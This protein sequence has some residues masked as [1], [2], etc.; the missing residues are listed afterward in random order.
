MHLVAERRARRS[1]APHPDTLD[2]RVADSASCPNCSRPIAAD[3]AFCPK[4]G[5]SLP[6]TPTV[7]PGEAPAAPAMAPEVLEE[8]LRAALAPGF[9]LVRRLGA[10]GM[11]SVYLARE[12]A[13]KRLVAVK[14]LAPELTSDAGSRA[15][16]EREAQAVAAFSHPNVVGIFGVGTLDD[17]TPYF[18]MQYVGGRSMSARV[19]EEGP[20]DVDEARRIIGEVASALA[21]A[22]AKGIIHRDIKPANILYDDD[23]SR[24]MVSDFGIAAVRA[25]GEAGTDTRLT[26]TGMIVGTPQYM[27]PE[28]LLAE[29]V[30]ERTDV[31]ALGLLGYELL[32]GK[33]PFEAATPQALIA[34]HL[35]DTPRRLS[36]TRKDLDP[37]LERLVMACLEKEPA[38]RPTAADLAKRLAPGAGTLLEWPPP[39]LD[40]LHGRLRRHATTVWLASLALTGGLL[41]FLVFGASLAGTGA[42][43]GVLLLTVLAIL[44][45]LG[46]LTAAARLE[47]DGR[48]AVRA[49]RA[50][51]TWL[52]VAEAAADTRGDSGALI[53]GGREYASLEPGVRGT[54]RRGRVARELLVLLGG[55]LPL[56][57]L[58]VAMWLGSRDVT[59]AGALPWLVFGPSVLCL[60]GAVLLEGLE[61]RT[62]RDTRRQ[63]SARRQPGDAIARLVAPWYASFDAVREGQALGRGRHGGAGIGWA[64]G[65]GLSVLALLAV[66]LLTPVLYVAARGSPP[67]GTGPVM[68]SRLVRA[69]I[70]RIEL[71]RALSVP[72]DSSID[73]QDAGVA[74]HRLA[75]IRTAWQAARGDTIALGAQELP[76]EEL[77]PWPD[78][79]QADSIFPEARPRNPVVPEY[80]Y[81][82]PTVLRR[83]T[84]TDAERRV[85][86]D[87][88]EHPAWPLVERVARAPAVDGL[89][90]WYALPFSSNAVS[91]RRSGPGFIGRGI[92]EGGVLR[93]AWFLHVG[94]PD[95]AIYTLRLVLSLNRSLLPAIS[96]QALSDIAY[97]RDGIIAIQEAAGRPEGAR[98]RARSDS[99]DRVLAADTVVASVPQD[100]LERRRYYLDAIADTT[101]PPGRRWLAART[102]ASSPCTNARELIFGFD[103]TSDSAL[104][105]AMRVLPRF[106]ADSAFVALLRTDIERLT[107]ED[108]EL[109]RRLPFRARA[110]QAAADFS[111]KVLGNPRIS[112]CVAVVRSQQR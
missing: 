82:I 96:T 85:L 26:Q 80:E 42:S 78:F 68:Q 72:V 81:V 29:E 86:R 47:R 22:H 53:S 5:A 31:Y 88:A 103:R 15:R 74:L 87:A 89:G 97:A 39:G 17:G 27:S 11:G 107:L 56:P 24:A 67:D 79:R 99:L 7:A 102:F 41:G 30:T 76:F 13:L 23:A 57:M 14:V 38:K 48:K 43:L 73:P 59:E 98:L 3:D 44:G 101:V 64:A 49:V 94:Q 100:P 112:R 12:P 106:P 6:G 2:V 92:A 55:L 16:F 63:S 61:A 37:E 91:W 10:G 52:T 28:A 77:P 95:S 54:L 62:V 36:E 46:L 105:L 84:L 19:A 4:C 20:L 65:F 60:L 104:T 109:R 1:L 90:G 50:G 71:V 51:F 40:A 111:G 33:G 75:R 18:V 58:I 108:V 21:A 45:G 69:R 66:I 34:M 70:A 110:L 83:R 25:K 35:R 32:A 8:K 93:A 9:L